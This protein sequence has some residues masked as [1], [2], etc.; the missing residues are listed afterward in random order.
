MTE[1]TRAAQFMDLTSNLAHQLNNDLAA[2]L[3]YAEIVVDDADPE[4]PV[5]GYATE[6]L[7][8]GRSVRAT[9]DRFHMLHRMTLAEI[10]LFDLR[11]PLERTCNTIF[12]RLNGAF[13]VVVDTPPLPLMVSGQQKEI[14]PIIRDLS[15]A[16]A[17][18]V[19]STGMIS[20]ALK[21]VETTEGT[22]L[23][24]GVLSQGSYARITILAKT[25]DC[26][27]PLDA[28]PDLTTPLDSARP[29]RIAGELASARSAIYLLGGTLHM[30]SQ[31]RNYGLA[32]VYLPLIS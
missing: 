23:S 14:E 29:G 22:R 1:M 15:E 27:V 7:L 9:V 11:L 30:H 8:A 2:I 25:A 3:G 17:S 10:G 12:A 32:E 26:E 28:S 5:N 16:V 18:I 6:I 21:T 20:L 13:K 24:H 19:G 4:D 31:N